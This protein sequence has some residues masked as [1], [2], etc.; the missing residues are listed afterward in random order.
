MTNNTMSELLKDYINNTVKLIV[1][2]PDEVEVSLTVSTKSVIIQL[3]SRKSDLGK[4]IGK[5]GRTVESLKIIIL[6]IKNT[7]FPN[8]TRRVILEIIE[9]E[10]SS[11]K[12]LN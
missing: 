11:Y 12:D 2:N 6:A 8:D 9:D 4:I 10:S 7:H 3:K 5:G 1:D